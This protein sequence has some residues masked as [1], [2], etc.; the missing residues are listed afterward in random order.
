MTVKNASEDFMSSGQRTLVIGCY[1]KGAI[2]GHCEA[3]DRCA[4]LGHQLAAAC[5]CRQ[6][7]HPD[8]SV[9]VP[10]VGPNNCKSSSQTLLL[11][12]VGRHILSQKPYDA[13]Y[14]P[15]YVALLAVQ[16]NIP[17]DLNLTERDQ[18]GHSLPL[19]CLFYTYA[20]EAVNGLSHMQAGSALGIWTLAGRG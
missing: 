8:V 20:S 16:I 15:C 9:L 19:V 12:G 5:V 13:K 18:A 1:H 7:P 17:A 2:Q 14:G 10:C 6:V 11:E 4:H 3:P